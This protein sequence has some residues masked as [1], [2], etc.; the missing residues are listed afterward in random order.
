VSAVF[1]GVS[2]LSVLLPILIAAICVL[3]VLAFWFIRRYWGG[4]RNVP[5]PRR[6]HTRVSVLH[7]VS[8]DA[9]RRLVMIRRDNV[10]HL[11]L[12]GGGADVV[13]EP[14]I[15]GS[16][17]SRGAKPARARAGETPAESPESH[18]G[19]HRTAPLPLEKRLELAESATASP[20]AHAPRGRPSGR[21]VLP[22]SAEQAIGAPPLNKESAPASPRTPVRPIP[23]WRL[24]IAPAAPE[25]A[26]PEGEAT[27]PSPASSR[28]DMAQRL[29]SVLGRVSRVS[30]VQTAMRN[31]TRDE[32]RSFEAGSQVLASNRCKLLSS[33][34]MVVSV[35]VN[36]M[37]ISRRVRLREASASE[38]P[39]NCRKRIRRCQNRRVTLPPGSAREN[40]EACPSGIRHVGG[41]KLDQ[42]LVRNVRTC[43]P[44]QRERSQAAQTARIRVPMRGTGAEQPVV[45]TK[46]L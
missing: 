37:R 16:T 41:A 4:Q 12:V 40:P 46:A 17:N 10:E 3:L 25:P 31:C 44:M 38:P 24:P 42:A 30:P 2:Q 19:R 39:M 11:L 21:E 28:A 45:G 15:V 26:A 34:A 23:L 5:L 27:S 1:D 13:V 36:V 6:R 35:A 9:R 20:L 29:E 33:K 43:A 8:I 14:N 7:S 32:G 22:R 18:P